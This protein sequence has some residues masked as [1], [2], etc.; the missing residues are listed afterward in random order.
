MI[1]LYRFER[2]GVTLEDADLVAGALDRAARGLDFADALHLG[3]AR[4]P[5]LGGQGRRALN[6]AGSGTSIEWRSGAP[7]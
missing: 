6:Q 1:T 2:S 5:P 3:R 7:Q 4:R